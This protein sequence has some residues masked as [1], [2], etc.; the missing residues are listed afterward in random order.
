[1]G[2]ENELLEELKEQISAEINL[3]TE[4]NAPYCY[5]MAQTAEQRQNLE[6]RI[7]E[8]VLVGQSID[9]AIQNTEREI[10]PNRID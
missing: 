4:A 5:A 9:E 6:D 1:M 2:G 3:I 8:K 7:A 10:N